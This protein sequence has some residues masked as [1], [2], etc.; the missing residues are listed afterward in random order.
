MR[1]LDTLEIR[2]S[3]ERKGK[4]WT[5]TATAQPFTIAAVGFVAKDSG[6]TQEVAGK[7]AVASLLSQIGRG[8]V[9]APREEP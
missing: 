2:L 5:A 9:P 6:A 8:Y 4:H 3:F 7:R 1:L